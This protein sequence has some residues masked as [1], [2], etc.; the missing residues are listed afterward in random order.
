MFDQGS[1]DKKKMIDIF[2]ELNDQGSLFEFI[3]K[4]SPES[5][6]NQGSQMP[7]G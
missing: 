6:L 5:N 7:G 1:T 2:E 3:Q 4:Y